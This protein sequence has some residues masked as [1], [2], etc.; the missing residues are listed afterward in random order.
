MA[1]AE[2]LLHRI[3]AEA[4]LAAPDGRLLH[5]YGLSDPHFA[6][7]PGV[8]GGLGPRAKRGRAIAALYVLWASEHIRRRYDGSG[9][10]W[11]FINNDV[12]QVF[13]GTTIAGFVRS[14][15]EVWLRPLRRGLGGNRLF[16]YTLL[17]EGGI[18]LAVLESAGRHTQVLRDMIDAICS[19]GGIAGL[20]YDTAFDMAHQK[21]RYLPN[22]LKDRDSVSLFLDL[23]QAI[24]DL[25]EALPPGLE[26]GHRQDWLDR[27]R[28]GW[29]SSLPLRVTPQIIEN[30]IRPSLAVSHPASR[31][32]SHPAIR[33]IHLTETGAAVPMAVLAPQASLPVLALPQDEA[34]LLRLVPRFAT[35]RPFAYR[36]LRAAEGGVRDL[37]RLGG[38]GPEVVPLGLG[39]TLDFDVMADSQSLGVWSA[40]PALPD[41]AEAPSL[42]AGQGADGLRL[43]QMSGGR[44]RAPSLWVTL[45]KGAAPGLDAVLVALRRIEIAGASLLELQ[46]QG[47]V[48]LGEHSLRIATEADSDSEP[49]ALHF[50]GHNLPTWRTTG[51]EP[52]YLGRPTV[53]GQKGDAALVALR[54]AQL[55]RATRPGSLFGAEFHEWWVEGERIATARALCLPA[56]LRVDMKETPDG[57]LSVLLSGLPDG[58]LADLRAGTFV[59]H[60]PAGT[61]PLV[62]GTRAPTTAFVALTL[63]EI[64]TGRRL[65]MTAPW[66]SSQ[67]QFI[68]DGAVL[69]RRDLDLSLDELAKVSYLAPGSRCK[70][71]INLA[72]GKVFD[73]RV[74]GLAPLVRH[75]ALL[76]R[77]MTQGTADSTVTLWLQTLAG[78]TGRINLRRYHGQMALTGDR[79]TLGL[80]ADLARGAMQEPEQ[81]PGR[82]DLHML[83]LETGE[84]REWSVDLVAQPVDLR[85]DTGIETG[86]WLVQ[87]RFDGFQQRPVAWLA[88]LPDPAAPAVPRSSRAARIAAYR[89]KLERETEA[90]PL[91]ALVRMILSAREGGDP[92]MLDQF[93]ALAASPTALAHMLFVLSDDDVK[94][95]FSF[96]AYLGMF[97]PA[98]PVATLVAVACAHLQS[99][100][101]G[102]ARAGIEGAEAMARSAMLGR[103]ALLR[104]MRPDMAGHVARLLIETELMV[105][106]VRDARFEGLLLPRP[107]EV[108]DE[109]IQMIA[110]SDPS[111][112][113]G[114]AA[115]RPACL[116]MPGKDFQQTV[117][118]TI[119]A[120]LVTAEAA[121]GRPLDGDALLNASL[122]ETAAPE[123]FARA[124]HPAL[125]LPLTEKRT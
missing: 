52:V 17:A 3:L 47:L 33:E 94:S 29:Q 32:R 76:R 42:W 41:P 102:L 98:F 38:S 43:R 111:L 58:L 72:G 75:E 103:L 46:G 63:T 11:E 1:M 49:A 40:L 87:G 124:L 95:L 2:D 91:R 109:A 81:R 92:A 73:V 45:P 60:A 19:R 23:A 20:G 108:L 27:E 120:V 68:R 100:A 85:T 74:S 59:A 69:Q 14:G 97:W 106:V 99:L 118:M 4:G 101:Q 16:M 50:F 84:T 26:G 57:G 37:E 18:P 39:E 82:A 110:R 62:L 56:D 65:E 61:G 80:G 89:A 22:I 116:A 114:I 48:T 78:Q 8:L 51:G 121:L 66:P 117:Q 79:L 7:I 13:D 12:P 34:S 115:L 93:H 31:P 96:D 123:L 24:H 35:R 53:Y 86:L 9:L 125:L 10:S 70:L 36:A 21:M 77:L 30:I 90:A 122:I 6:A 44:T 54:G 112:P 105:H 55:R 67:P 119:G 28:P 15:L 113:R 88:T 64:A 5:A 107:H 83:H 104:L 71:T 25:R